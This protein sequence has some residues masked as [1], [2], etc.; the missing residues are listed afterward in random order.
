MIFGE[1][2]IQQ[3]LENLWQTP[4]CP[5]LMTPSKA[6]KFKKVQNCTSQ[7]KHMQ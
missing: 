6:L 3:G 5:P 1:D 2:E 4:F 7:I